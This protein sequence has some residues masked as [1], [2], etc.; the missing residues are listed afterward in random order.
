MLMGSS[1]SKSSIMDYFTQFDITMMK[2]QQMTPMALMHRLENRFHSLIWI[3][4]GIN[5]SSWCYLFAIFT[6]L[7]NCE[8]EFGG[9]PLSVGFYQ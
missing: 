1:I 3:M 8:S 7:C 5:Y 6:E 4:M 2:L 9:F